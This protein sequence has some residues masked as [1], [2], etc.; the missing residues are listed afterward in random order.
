MAKV[1]RNEA[2]PCGSGK[3][4]K[5]CCGKQSVVTSIHEL[6][7]QELWD[8]LN[9][10]CVYT[11]E[12]DPA[13]KRKA[14]A[15]KV[16]Q[17]MDVYHTAFYKPDSNGVRLIERFIEKNHASMKRK[18]TRESIEAWMDVEVGFFEIV[19]WGQDKVAEIKNSITGNRSMVVF[20]E[21]EAADE[22]LRKADFFAGMIGKWGSCYRFLP[23]PLQLSKADYKKMMEI[24]QSLHEQTDSSS[25]EEVVVSRYID[26]ITQFVEE[27]VDT[28]AA[29]KELERDARYQEVL[30]LFRMHSGLAHRR[31][32]IA[33][34]E[35]YWLM[36]C[37]NYNIKGK[38][39]GIYAAA[40][41]YLIRDSPLFGVR[42]QCTQKKIADKYGVSVTSIGKR[43]ADL[44]EIWP[45]FFAME[46]QIV[47][48][49]FSEGMVTDDILPSTVLFPLAE[50]STYE[51]T[52]RLN[53]HGDIEDEQ[54]LRDLLDKYV[55]ASFEP[56][57]KQQQAQLLVYEAM[58]QASDVRLNLIEQALQLDPYNSDA[59]TV[60]AFY[61]EDDEQ[62]LK[63]SQTAIRAAKERVGEVFLQEEM[64]S[65]W[66]HL[67]ARP[68]LRALAGLAD[69]Y[70]MFG[71]EEQSIHVL[72]DILEANTND[73][74]GIRYELIRLYLECEQYDQAKALRNTFA[75]D[76]HFSMLYNDVLIHIGLHA[77]RAHIEKL[78]QKAISANPEVAVLL[79]HPTS[80]PRDDNWSAA[81]IQYAEKHSLA[82]YGHEHW[83]Q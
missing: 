25:F 29:M 71:M 1:N 51:V 78:I 27:P 62:A 31:D 74:Q 65:L 43:L 42:E 45:A 18:Q 82:W 22:R 61:E 69:L 12:N 68:Y 48:D 8:N 38:K 66:G 34:A 79:E 67:S 15:E 49:S 4:Y 73:N 46:Q 20:T 47:D 81:A 19:C 7:N 2:C 60:K 40:L 26:I 17:I 9:E 28:M 36:Y 21:E 33:K 75:E 6:V 5:K 39:M 58:E 59:N 37:L 83:L 35:R 57:T 54:Q 30:A 44:D 72:E 64:G 13:V 53:S 77:S 16:I 23:F 24:A 32:V 11:M 14:Y 63:Y 41:E 76:A 80:I 50:R 55:E 56:E 10:L 3:K 52:E 70:E